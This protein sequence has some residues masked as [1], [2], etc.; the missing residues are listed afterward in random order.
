MAVLPPDPVF[1]LRNAEM[2]PVV[3]KLN[4]IKWGGG[5][6]LGQTLMLVQQNKSMISAQ[7]N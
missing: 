2:G 1:N 7:R 6:G 5:E 3:C 4:F